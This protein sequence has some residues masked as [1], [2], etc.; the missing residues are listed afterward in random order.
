MKKLLMAG[1]GGHASSVV[2]V[3]ERMGGWQIAGLLDSHA[4]AGGMRLGYEILG[5]PEDVAE[6]AGRHGIEGLLVAVGDNWRRRGLAALLRDAV[7]SI[8]F[9]RAIHPAAVVGKNVSI[10]CGT[11][12]MAGA[13]INAN[14]R[15]G[16]FCIVNTRASLDHDGAMGDYASLA[17]GVTAGGNVAI[18]ELSA[19]CIGATVSHKVRIGRETVVGAGSTVLHDLGD[20]L[21][22]YGAPARRVRERG[23]DEIYLR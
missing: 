22:A 12:V 16:D 4:P 5:R 13:V 23:S 9:I 14:C 21:V 17:P 2:D 1:A 18:G 20:G 10:G 7:P 15:I 3:V 11:V 8:P 6:L 19:I